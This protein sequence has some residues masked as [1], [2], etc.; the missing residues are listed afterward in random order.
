M[1]LNLPVTA[2]EYELAEGQTL[3]STTDLQSH[4]TY[5]NAAFIAVSGYEREELL[6]QPHN[7]VRHP[8][9][10]PEAF[11]D[12]WESIRAGRPWSAAGQEPP[13]ERRPL[14]GAGQRHAADGSGRTGGLHVGAHQAGARAGP[15]GR[16]AVRQACASRPRQARCACA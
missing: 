16:G 9:M 13:Q 6:G 3:V 7:M 4:I 2:N 15:P 12:M 10:P 8:D 1:K 11:R 14:L 5:C